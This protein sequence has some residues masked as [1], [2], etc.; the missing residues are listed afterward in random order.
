M[1]GEGVSEGIP[2]GLGADNTGNYRQVT[3]PGTARTAWVKEEDR[4]TFSGNAH[5]TGIY[6]FES[7]PLSGSSILVMR[8]KVAGETIAYAAL[9]SILATGVTN[10]VVFGAVQGQQRYHGSEAKTLTTECAVHQEA[11]SD[12]EEDICY[13]HWWIR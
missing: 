3:Y 12:Q 4:E 7:L 5:V 13:E 9:N 2:F 10:P 6:S 1:N 11:G 8:G